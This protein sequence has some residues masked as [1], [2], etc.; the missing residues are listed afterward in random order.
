[1]I[2][3]GISFSNL[4]A[5]EMWDSGESQEA[6]VG[7]RTISAPRA[8]RTFTFS[9]LIFSGMTIMHRYPLTAPHSAR[10]IP[11]KN[12]EMVLC[13]GLLS[14]DGICCTYSAIFH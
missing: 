6:E 13:N 12:V 9:L 1:M 14:T 8:L 2:A 4:L 3:P 10:P 11:E 7:V 5:T